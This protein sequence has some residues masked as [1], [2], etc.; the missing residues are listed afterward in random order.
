M[1]VSSLSCHANGQQ[2]LKLRSESASPK[3]SVVFPV[4]LTWIEGM[5]YSG[6]RT[7]CQTT[8]D[9]LTWDRLGAPAFGNNVTLPG[10]E[11]SI[12]SQLLCL[13]MNALIHILVYLAT[14]PAA[15][16]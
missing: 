13:M 6:K 2:K 3:V 5:R 1:N 9:I 14:T 15:R 12:F 7:H 11:R 16:Q 10:M 4:V 8:A